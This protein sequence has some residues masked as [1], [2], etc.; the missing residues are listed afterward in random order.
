MFGG[1]VSSPC[2]NII[3][4]CSVAGVAEE[5]VTIEALPVATLTS[6][7]PTRCSVPQRSHLASFPHQT[8]MFVLS[9]TQSTV[10]VTS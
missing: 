5:F 6:N 3:P 4:M 9:N 2:V 10:V 7:C 1:I 8:V